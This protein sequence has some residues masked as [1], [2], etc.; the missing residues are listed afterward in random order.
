[1]RRPQLP[2]APALVSWHCIVRCGRAR[3]QELEVLVLRGTR[4]RQAAAD[5]LR[6]QL[7]RLHTAAVDRQPA[8]AA[9]AP[10]P[11]PCPPSRP[12]GGAAGL[13]PA[14]PTAC[15]DRGDDAPVDRR[16]GSRMRCLPLW[17][18]SG[19][20][21]AG[22]GCTGLRWGL[23]RACEKLD[24]AYRFT[25]VGHLSTCIMPC[26]A[27]REEPQFRASSACIAST[28]GV[29]LLHHAARRCRDWGTVMLGRLIVRR[30]GQGLW[31]QWVS[32]LS[33]G[34]QRR[35][36]KCC[37]RPGLFRGPLEVTGPRLHFFLTPSTA[38]SGVH[39]TE[40]PLRE[41]AG[42]FAVLGCGLDAIVRERWAFWDGPAV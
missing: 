21:A 14:R 10:A 22:R 11:G 17:W 7:P 32:G 23:V 8:L 40:P 38:S 26:R 31:V 13:R 2:G 20:P 1:M 9:R 12:P 24:Q 27:V 41:A 33:P 39:C 3:A 16:A 37:R 42:N 4:V 34:S 30:G 6:L 36:C 25:G 28:S 15:S 18:P 35:L 5:R 29:P 19:G